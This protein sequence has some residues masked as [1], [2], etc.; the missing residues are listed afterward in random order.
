MTRGQVSRDAAPR[1]R[2]GLETRETTEDDRENGTTGRSEK[3]RTARGQQR[4]GQQ[5]ADTEH[6]QER[7]N[8][9]RTT[10]AER[11]VS[12]AKGRERWGRTHGERRRGRQQKN[13]HGGKRAIGVIGEIN[14][15]LGKV[16][17][18]LATGRKDTDLRVNPCL[19]SY[20]LAKNTL[21]I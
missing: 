12:S 1:Q 13:R 8:S 21:T 19:F 16:F 9:Q 4:T 5:D 17:G 2:Q 7:T 20:F 18:V 10:R 15:Y 3:G 6:Q 14:Y 11:E